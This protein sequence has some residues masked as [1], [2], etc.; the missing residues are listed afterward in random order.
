MADTVRLADRSKQLSHFLPSMIFVARIWSFVMK[1]FAQT[2]SIPLPISTP[3]LKYA[4]RSPL[5]KSG[6]EES[7]RSMDDFMREVKKLFEG[8]ISLSNLLSMSTNLQEQYAEKL[9]SSDI[10]MLPSY[11]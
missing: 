6:G 5:H 11:N 3:S 1:P 7:I 10:C 4:P 9:Q 2:T 8:P